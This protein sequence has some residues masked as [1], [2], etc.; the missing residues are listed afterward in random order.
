M[1]FPPQRRNHPRY[2]VRK[3]ASYRYGDKQ[4]LTLTLDLGLGGMKINTCFFLP[5]E[6]NLNFKLVLGTNST[7]LKGRIAYSRFDSDN[8]SVSGIQFIELSRQDHILL[9]DYLAT[10]EESPKGRGII[11]ADEGETA[12]LDSIRTADE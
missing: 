12:P 7:W 5:E 10:L 2:P 4:F 1:T 8:Q 6:E 11:F 3:I 9:R